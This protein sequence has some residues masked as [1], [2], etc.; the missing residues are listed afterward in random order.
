VIV[1]ARLEQ[2]NKELETS[3]LISKAVVSSSKLDLEKFKFLGERMVKGF[4]N[5]I[6][7]FTVG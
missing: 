6:E 3:I 5:P 4:E 2:M 1:A 7:V